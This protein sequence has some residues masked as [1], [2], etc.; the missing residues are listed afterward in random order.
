MVRSHG[1]GGLGRHLLDGLRWLE[2]R[3]GKHPTQTDSTADGQCGAAGRICRLGLN[4]VYLYSDMRRWPAGIMNGGGCYGLLS[5]MRLCGGGVSGLRDLRRSRAS[6]LLGRAW[7]DGGS[8]V[9]SRDVVG[10][11][12]VGRRGL[13]RLSRGR[14]HGGH[15][16]R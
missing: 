10:E 5:L 1:I 2:L 8:G 6:M 16:L 7:L 4:V 15:P 14:C 12:F 11:I 13:E 3:R 9:C